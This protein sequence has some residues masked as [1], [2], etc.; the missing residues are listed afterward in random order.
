LGKVAA[1]R[2]AGSK[3]KT[4][5]IP[6]LFKLREDFV[7][8]GDIVVVK[9][10]VVTNCRNLNRI[11][12]ELQKKQV[13]IYDFSFFVMFDSFPRNLRMVYF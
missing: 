10:I 7:F 6:N 12:M 5:R 4:K 8:L 3:A 11:K 9:S 2:E 1:R 13:R